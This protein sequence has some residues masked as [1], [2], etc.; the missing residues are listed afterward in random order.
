LDPAPEFVDESNSSRGAEAR[1]TRTPDPG[2]SASMGAHPPAR[3]W[4]QV[5]KSIAS[6]AVAVSAF[7]L[8]LAWMGGDFRDKVRPGE[9]P[10]GRPPAAG[11]TLDTVERVRGEETATA[12][13]SVQP[14]KRTEVA[15]QLL[16]TVL[17]VRVRPGDR[18]KP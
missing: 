18:V 4:R 15:S 6:V 1:S 7:G 3:R 12:V 10:A 13:G 14:K 17:D 5:V 11:R 2:V 9:V 8:L 16:A